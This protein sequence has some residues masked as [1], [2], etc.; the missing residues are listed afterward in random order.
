MKWM[1]NV[2]G[3]VLFLDHLKVFDDVLAEFDVL[4]YSLFPTASPS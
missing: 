1:F 2:S 4:V 3:F